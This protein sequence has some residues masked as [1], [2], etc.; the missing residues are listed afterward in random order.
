MGIYYDDDAQD[1]EEISTML[2]ACTEDWNQKFTAEEHVILSINSDGDSVMGISNPIVTFSALGGEL[3]NSLP[4]EPDAFKRVATLLVLMCAY[5]FIIG[6][7]ED[8]DGVYQKVLHGPD[9]R[10]FSVRF[11]IDS[12][13]VLFYPLDQENENGEWVRIDWKGFVSAE[14]ETEFAAILLDIARSGI[15]QIVDRRFVYSQDQL[16][17]AIVNASVLLKSNYGAF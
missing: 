1:V 6:R 16:A 10:V 4:D 8:S 11:A 3:M 13:P 12:L 17:R 2:Q 14:V 15:A 9:L 7:V 5:P